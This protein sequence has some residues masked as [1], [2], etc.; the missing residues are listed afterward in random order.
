MT[1]DNVQT[2]VTFENGMLIQS[3]IIHWMPRYR[4]VDGQNVT[5]WGN[6]DT[7]FYL[8]DKV[9]L[10]PLYHDKDTWALLSPIEAIKLVATGQES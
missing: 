9:A 8:N 4:L 1:T 6:Y 10:S 3:D 5:N 2:V 7:M